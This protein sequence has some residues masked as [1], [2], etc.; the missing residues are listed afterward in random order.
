MFN[1]SLLVMISRQILVYQ[2]EM[3][4]QVD[5]KSIPICAWVSFL[6]V[7]LV[8]TGSIVFYHIV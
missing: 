6:Y 1:I 7:T 3:N 2:K 8:M 5:Q 4:P